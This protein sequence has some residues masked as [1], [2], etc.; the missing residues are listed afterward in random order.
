MAKKMAAPN[1]ME[2]A[3]DKCRFC[4]EHLGYGVRWLHLEVCDAPA[5]RR[6]NKAEERGGHRDAEGAA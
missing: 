5:C 4:G 3:E 1:E 6:K 2:F